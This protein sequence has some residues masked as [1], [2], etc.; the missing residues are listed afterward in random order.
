MKAYR[1]LLIIF[2]SLSIIA[3]NDDEE[4]SSVNQ[5][6]DGD[7]FPLNTGNQWEYGGSLPFSMESTGNTRTINNNT[8]TEVS[9][10]QLG[11]DAPIFVS[12]NN[13]EYSFVG[14]LPGADEFEVVL[15]R[16]N[17]P[18]GTT[19]DN[20][21]VI[22]GLNVN[23]QVTISEKGGSMTVSEEEFS[24][25]IGVRITTTVSVLGISEELATQDLYFARNVGIILNDLDDLGVSELV[26]YTVND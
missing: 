12:V 4:A 22:N 21:Q 26:E 9:T 20:E 1:F 6:S 11:N 14:F 8:Y 19:W 10:D 18:E 24:D 3:C 16:D 15:L 17:V 7:F 13:G 5:N 23:Y 25:V 2:L